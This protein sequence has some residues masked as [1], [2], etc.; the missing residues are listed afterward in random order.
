MTMDRSTGIKLCSFAGLASVAA[1]GHYLGFP[2]GV[3]GILPLIFTLG[4]EGAATLAGHMGAHLLV[5]AAEKSGKHAIDRVRGRQ[6]RDVHRLIGEA[7]ALML[8]RAAVDAP[9]GADGAAYLSGAAAA[10]R[11]DWMAVELTADEAAIGEPEVARYF[12]GDSEAIKH[13]RVLTEEQWFALVQRVAGEIPYGGALALSP[14]RGVADALRHAAANLCEKFAFELWEVAKQAWDR[15]DVAWP[16]LIMRLLSEML[17][18]A[19]TATAGNADLMETVRKI[20]SQIQGLAERV[21]TQAGK[22]TPDRSDELAG[23][24]GDAI[25]EYKQEIDSLG[26]ALHLLLAGQERLTENSEAIL[27]EVR[28][29]TERNPAGQVEGELTAYLGVVDRYSKKE[30]GS[31][32]LRE[33]GAA[34]GATR[35][36]TEIVQGHR[37]FLIYTHD[38]SDTAS[39][40]MA[41]PGFAGESGVLE[42]GVIPIR[43]PLGRWAE[44]QGVHDLL[45]ATIGD[46]MWASADFIAYLRQQIEA[47]RALLV[48]EAPADGRVS[49]EAL[50]W[51]KEELARG[52]AHQSRLC[53]VLKFGQQLDESRSL[54]FPIF[55]RPYNEQGAYGLALKLAVVG[56]ETR[57]PTEEIQGKQSVSCRIGQSWSVVFQVSDNCYLTLFCRGTTGN[58]YRLHLHPD[59]HEAFARRGSPHNIPRAGDEFWF[60]EGGPAGTEVI[61]AFATREPMGVHFAAGA[62]SGYLC[63]SSEGELEG[64][65]AEFRQMARQHCAEAQCEIT[66]ED[67]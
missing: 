6:N 28:R 64:V 33:P 32:R 10:F 20:S 50:R 56:S 21:D 54:G 30:L 25:R 2:E 7:I 16:A 9:G 3:N 8:E 49:R 11:Q 38:P 14:D 41:L 48:L 37:Q 46:S 26:G 34:E 17:G 55:V 36:L 43:L 40:L 42:P 24:I 5:D 60:K 22:M 1:A 27:R 52:T 19:K 47:G 44:R 61:S 29:I 59:G 65:R 58:L 31:I 15:N 57:D 51:I 35:S 63:R 23:L 12:A 4:R 62:R 13:V 66:V 67:G 53:V 18:H 39:L 45:S